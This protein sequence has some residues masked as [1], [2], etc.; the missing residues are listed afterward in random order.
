MAT[1]RDILT[2]AESPVTTGVDHDTP[3]G[4]F[5]ATAKIVG[6]Y[7]TYLLLGEADNVTAPVIG[8]IEYG[9]KATVYK[10][11]GLKGGQYMRMR[12]PT[13]AFKVMVEG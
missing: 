7:T 6:V 11:R 10:G 4:Y 9:R 12:W 3:A 1:L 2:A 8:R 13:M 5:C